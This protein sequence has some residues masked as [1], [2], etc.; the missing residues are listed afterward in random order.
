MSQQNIHR[1]IAFIVFLIAAATYF[2]TAQPSLS[3]WDC[4]EFI[5]SSYAL[6]V[7]HPPG[8]PFFI[9]IGRF[10][11]MI[12]FAEN[13]A[14]RVNAISILS[15]ALVIL[16]LYLSVVKLIENYN[17]KKYDSSLSQIGT[18]FSAAIG[19]L[20]LAFADTFWF[21]AT[22]AEV[23]AFSTFFIAFV[24]WLILLWNEKADNP[25]NE[26]YLIMIAYLIGLSIGVHLMSVLAM[27][28][29][30][31]VVMF[32]KY[33][34]D[35][36]VTKKT[37]YL[38]L[39][40]AIGTVIIALAIWATATDTTAPNPEE[41]KAFDLRF[42]TLIGIFWLVYMGAMWK[43]VF[44]KNSFY[45]PIM[46]GGVMLIS[47]YPGFVKYIP[48]LIY[49]LSG[50][51]F[52]LNITV[53]L[54]IFLAV[55]YLIYWSQKNNKQ[56][57]N[58]LA[59]SVLFILLGYSTYSMTMIRANQDT[60]INLNDPKTMSEFHSYMNREQYGDFPAFKRRFSQ[61]GHQQKIYTNYSSDL[62]F[63]WNY[64]MDRMFNRYLGWNYIGRDS[65][66]QG[67]GVNFWQ[68]LAIP[69]LLGLFGIYYQF[70]RD[71]KMA[72][73]MMAMFIF[74]G[75]LTVFYQ[76][77]QQ[78]QPRERDYFYV[79]AFFVYSIWI[80]L[81][82]RGLLDLIV[83]QF[84]NS[85]LMKPVFSFIML[86]ILLAV[87]VTMMKANYFT[88]DRSNNFVPWDYAY[89]LLQSVAPNAVLFTNGDNDTFPLW[90]LQDV[91]GV[92]RDVRVANLS[93]LNTPWYVKQLKNTAPYGSK[94]I[95]MN[96]SDREVDRIGPSRWEPRTM[97]LAVPQAVFTEA[98]VTDTSI[99]NAG[100]ISWH[101]KNTTSYSNIKVVRIQDLVALSILQAANWERPVY[102][103]VTC[104]EDSRLGLDD[105]LQME[106]MAFK[107]VPKKRDK[108][109]YYINEELM[110]KQLFNEP[111][112][113][114]RTYQPGFKFR[115]LNDTTI[116]LDENHQR[117]SQNYRNSFLRL[118]IYYLDQSQQDKAVEVLDEMEKKLPRKN[119]KMRYELLYDISNLYYSAGANE[120]YTAMVNE[121]EP[122]MV[123]RLEANPRDFQRQYNPYVVL[124][125][126]YENREDYEKLAKLF[127]GL[128]KE[129]PADANIQGTVARYKALAKTKLAA[130]STK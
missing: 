29:I 113:Y 129:V 27:V 81:G 67:S 12:P 60:P 99:T 109:V 115:G 118:A 93:L 108:P 59:K 45:I 106:G 18:Y 128:A 114:S 130:D 72:S 49:N 124:R 3:F 64:Q 66:V 103:A 84:K 30:V 8:T 117:L 56:T 88:H 122:I 125:D 61:E 44:Q 50:N 80:G 57:T 34:H 73:A 1:I 10:L 121:L 71:W 82:T 20:S 95:A 36:V 69:F 31:M 101:M 33:L 16:F 11:S 41:Y 58:L 77:Q 68:F 43:K 5:A 54:G 28:P 23:Y 42:V 48:K 63:F 120:Q 9:L 119:I 22:E 87:P 98:G 126:I 89:N 123:A 26:K 92:R 19:A 13:I 102:Y 90:Y 76:N 4:G 53:F 86:L 2:A 62:D 46:I 100:S 51:D 52:T 116:F 83:T 91:E 32:R 96:M 37:A 14:F 35:D 94:K 70:R 110:R 79:G 112:D 47:V 104:A 97:R 7:P 74:L 40:Q 15:S 21:N 24:T 111:A 85:K 107:L 17:K 105:Y 65:T 55:G 127:E 75:Y 38:F 39:F 6:Q 78:P 25:D